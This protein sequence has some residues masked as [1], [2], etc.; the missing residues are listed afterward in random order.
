M[1][2]VNAD[3][4]IAL[5]ERPR[6]VPGLI[7]DR[8]P[9]LGEHTILLHPTRPAWALAN[10]T[11]VLL[12][13]M[14]DGSRT[15][16]EMAG[17]LGGRYGI[18]PGE[19]ESDIDA[20]LRSLARAGLLEG[21]PLP[22]PATPR[23]QRPPSMTIYITEECNL[24]CRHCAIVEGR[25]PK[26]L[27]GRAEIQRLID[28]H[29]AAH[30]NPTIA[31]LG[32]EPLLHPDCLPLLEY[33]TRR[34]RV[35]NISTNGLLVTAEVAEAL[36]ALP[37]NVQVS[38]DGADPAVHDFIRGKGS[39]AKT[40]AAV[41]LL[42]AK[43]DPARLTIA[44][45]LTRSL[46]GQV[47]D[48][49]ARCDRFRIGKLRFLPLNKTKAA[50]TNWELIEP[51]YQ[52]LYRTIRWLIFDAPARPGAVTEVLG[53]FPGFVPDPSP[54]AH[55]CPLGRTAI[56]NSQGKVYT[57]PSLTTPEVTLGSVFDESLEAMLG[58]KGTEARSMMLQRRNIVDDC[59][60]CSWRNYCQGGC[61]AYMQHQSG[62]FYKNDEHCEFR[63][64]LYREYVLRQGVAR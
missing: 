64:N 49:V 28:E 6:T 38:V 27:M 39:F 20:F 31:F 57:C 29:A 43:G 14:A 48:L 13:E 19:L 44:S 4:A 58:G 52:E 5:A 56:V 26:T 21:Q 1:A 22:T 47:Q 12:A 30:D 34:T 55:W 25:M 37:V 23:P 2:P 59:R 8:A 18:A 16:A 17:E 9:I 7:V 54:D 41:E 60:S 45:V 36:A 15:V 11:G 42:A 46:L 53:S 50:A 61:G 3:I 40:L 63:R 24:R 35:V 10:E 62:S 33:A 32:G 51:D